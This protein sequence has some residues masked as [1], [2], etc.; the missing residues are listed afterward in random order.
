MLRANW[1]TIIFKGALNF[2]IIK[3]V[4][5]CIYLTCALLMILYFLFY[6]DIQFALLMKNTLLQFHG[7]SGL[8][9]NS[10]KS[11]VFLAGIEGDATSSICQALQVTRGSL[12]LKYLGVPLISSR[13][14]KRDCDELI[15][16][17]C[18]C[19]TCIFP[20]FSNINFV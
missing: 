10:T 20:I 13:L 12:P 5:N 6:S 17:I 14:K 4:T 7:F 8:Q 16:K 18:I 3:N 19:N 1:L 9:A 2:G 11:C 15:S